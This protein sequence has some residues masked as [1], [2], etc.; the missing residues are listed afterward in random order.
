MA[1][2]H[3]IMQSNTNK[4]IDNS[5]T[6]RVIA[7]RAECPADVEAIR[8]LM[9]P[10]TLGY[11]TEAPPM[12]YEGKRC[13]S[14]D[15]DVKMTL[16]AQAPS[17]AELRYIWDAVPN[18]HICA[19]TLEQEHE[20]TGE[21][22]PRCPWTGDV[23]RPSKDDLSKA[24]DAVVRRQEVLEAELVRMQQTYRDLRA[25]HDLGE[26]WTPPVREG[27]NPGTICLATLPGTKLTRVIVVSPTNPAAKQTQAK[28]KREVETRLLVINS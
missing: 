2:L 14:T 13:R 10:W 6:E 12:E 25:M 8:A 16:R 28:G 22:E 15:V 24:L 3:L 11:S 20:Y 23:A 9:T 18:I 7:F 27:Y 4:T 19:D 5:T 17:V 26:R 21:R 1:R